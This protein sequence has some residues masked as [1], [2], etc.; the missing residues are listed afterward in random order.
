MNF[1]RKMISKN[2]DI[3]SSRIVLISIGTV[4]VLFLLACIAVM[5]IDTIKEGRIQT[6]YFSGIAE[7]IGALAILLG[8][9]GFTKNLSDKWQN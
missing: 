3:S 6:N 9:A 8:A 5:I 1:I 4:V 7:I 2:T